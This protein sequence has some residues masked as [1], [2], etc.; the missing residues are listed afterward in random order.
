MKSCADEEDLAGEGDLLKKN[1]FSANRLCE[2]DVSEEFGFPIKFDL[3]VELNTA[4]ICLPLEGRGIDDVPLVEMG[5]EKSDVFVE[6]GFVE[7]GRPMEVGYS[8]AGR[9]LKVGLGSGID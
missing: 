8:E 9:R 6:C 7:I 1:L 2:E 5:A 3:L 4:K